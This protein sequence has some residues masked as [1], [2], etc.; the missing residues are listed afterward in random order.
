[1]TK[2]YCQGCSKE[3][4]STMKLCPYCGA[5]AFSPNPVAANPALQAQSMQVNKSAPISSP[6]NNTIHTTTHSTNQLQT[7]F[8]PSPYVKRFAAAIIDYL[9]VVFCTIIPIAIA[10]L[11]TQPL[12]NSNDLMVLRVLFVLV[13]IFL[14]YAYY[15]L[16]HSSEKQATYGKIAMKLKIVTV[17]GE[18]L[19]RIQAFVRVMLTAIIPIIG[20]LLLVFSAAGM[21]IQ[22][23]TDLQQSI[24]VSIFITAIVIYLGPFAM[25][26]FTAQRQTL[27]DLICKTLVIE[28]KP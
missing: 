24:G 11:I 16:M 14:P 2:Q 20:L 26:F 19:T 23:K 21:S 17:Q 13:S 10:Q 28:D 8:Y 9:I 12:S 6:P 27:F 18:R 22:Y 15:T 4:M 3:L 5:K 1:M 7:N 25:I